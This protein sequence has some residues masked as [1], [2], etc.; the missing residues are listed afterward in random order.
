M[1]ISGL[2]SS[3]YVA[4][5]V[6]IEELKAK[7]E[8]IAKLNNVSVEQLTKDA[9]VAGKYEDGYLNRALNLLERIE[10]LS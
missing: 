10:R 4:L 6:T 3:T 8:Q 5:P 1:R 9:K 2:S 7:L